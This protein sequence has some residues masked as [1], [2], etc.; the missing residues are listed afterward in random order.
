MEVLLK[1]VQNIED[2]VNFLI[3]RM[4]QSTSVCMYGYV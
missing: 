2:V 3:P 1:E 4:A